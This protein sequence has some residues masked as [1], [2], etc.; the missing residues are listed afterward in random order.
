MSNSRAVYLY[1]QQKKMVQ[2]MGIPF[3]DLFEAHYLSADWTMWS[4]GRHYVGEFNRKVLN[5]FYSDSRNETSMALAEKPDEDPK[6]QAIKV[7]EHKLST[8]IF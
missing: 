7:D 3:I 4:D 5:W 6:K 8:Y 1:D 2:E